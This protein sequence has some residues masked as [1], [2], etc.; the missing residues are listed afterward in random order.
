MTI[1]SPT[2][3]HQAVTDLSGRDWKIQ[4]EQSRDTLR[5]ASGQPVRHFA[6]PVRDG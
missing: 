6:Y 1:G 3:D 5:K 4:L 2:Y